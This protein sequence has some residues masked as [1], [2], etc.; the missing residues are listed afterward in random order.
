MFPEKE[1]NGGQPIEFHRGE[2]HDQGTAMTTDLEGSTID[3]LFALREEVIEVLTEK[4]VCKKMELEERLRLLHSPETTRRSYPP[5]KA[6]FRN[7]DQPSETWSGRGRLPRWLDAQLRS[8]KR[9][10]QFRIAS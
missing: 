3:E 2:A 9:L 8:G 7:P 1:P 4:L 10:D 6:K 5:V